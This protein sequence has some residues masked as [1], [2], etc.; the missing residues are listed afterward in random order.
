MNGND[1]IVSRGGNDIFLSRV[2]HQFY[3]V[4]RIFPLFVENNSKLFCPRKTAIYSSVG[5]QEQ[6]CQFRVHGVFR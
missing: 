1:I 6:E 4:N 3:E 5:R 2:T